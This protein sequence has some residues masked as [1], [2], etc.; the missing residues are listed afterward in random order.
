[1]VVEV[2][3]P[4]IPMTS[5][6]PEPLNLGS[7]NFHWSRVNSSSGFDDTSGLNATGADL[8]LHGLA[9]FDISDALKIWV[10]AFFGFIMGMTYTVAYPRSLSANIAYTRHNESPLI[11]LQNQL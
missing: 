3:Q 4:R 11:K 8:H 7:T 9:V 1:M 5:G 2:F 10:P 6:N